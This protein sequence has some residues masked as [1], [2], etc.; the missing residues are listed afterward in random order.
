MRTKVVIAIAAGGVVHLLGSGE[1]YGLVVVGAAGIYV[2]QLAF[3]SGAL[4]T[5]L[6]II[7]V[8]EP[9]SAA[10]LGCALLHEHFD[11]A[12]PGRAV[13]GVAIAAMTVATIKLAREEA[14]IVRALEE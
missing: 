4:Q 12:G 2:Q 13:L 7:A 6:P 10:L 8:L 9:M 11:I 3:Q 14:V 5:S 1:L